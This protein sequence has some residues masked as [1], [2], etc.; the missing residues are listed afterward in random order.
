MEKEPQVS[1][2]E[3]SNRPQVPEQYPITNLNV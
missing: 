3:R 2:H 1:A